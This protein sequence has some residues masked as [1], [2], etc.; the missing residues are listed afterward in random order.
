[1]SNSKHT[2]EPWMKGF[3]HVYDADGCEIADCM[4]DVYL[5]Y[6]DQA[7]AARI[8]ECVN[9]CAGIENPSYAIAFAIDALKMADHVRGTR[10]D[11]VEVGNALRKA[12]ELLTGERI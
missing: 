6:H 7:N 10:D 4:S 1:M 5:T 12:L 3:F 9:A 8:V 2:P 11:I